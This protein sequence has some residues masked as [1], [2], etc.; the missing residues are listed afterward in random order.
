M[1]GLACWELERSIPRDEAFR[2]R[3]RIAAITSA[4]IA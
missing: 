4:R 2:G 3:T 1:S